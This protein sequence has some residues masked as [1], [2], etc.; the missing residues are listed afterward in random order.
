MLNHRNAFKPLA[1]QEPI[2]EHALRHARVVGRLHLQ[3]K[4]PPVIQLRDQIG[5]PPLHRSEFHT[6]ML[7]RLGAR[8]SLGEA[9][10]QRLQYRLRDRVIVQRTIGLLSLSAV[11]NQIF[12]SFS[13]E[14]MFANG[15]R[16]EAVARPTSQRLEFELI[17]EARLRAMIVSIWNRSWRSLSNMNPIRSFF[18]AGKFVL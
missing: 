9:V 1:Q 13:Y 4:V 14:T 3:V 10:P 15:C 17:T 18:S 2:P 7:N 8:Q 12:S 5:N 6:E 11:S 16:H